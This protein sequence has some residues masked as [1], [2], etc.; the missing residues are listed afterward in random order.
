MSEESV[1]LL[2]EEE[3]EVVG[4]REEEVSIEFELRDAAQQHN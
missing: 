4:E 1:L 3:E 2:G